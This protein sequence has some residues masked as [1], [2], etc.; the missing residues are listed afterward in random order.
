MARTPSKEARAKMLRA[1]AQILFR[2]GI[3]A[4]TVEAVARRSGVAKTT[5][6]RHFGGL[7]GLVNAT[8]ADNVRQRAGPDTG[9][10]KGDLREIQQNYLDL[11]NSKTNREVFA[12]MMTR[13]IE[14]PAA[15]AHFRK[16]RSEPRGPTVVALQ[17][18]IAR[19]EVSPTIDI[20]LASHVI[21]GPLMS[22]RFV[23][24]SELTEDE[25]EAL[26]DMIL[27]ALQSN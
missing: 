22:K 7:D 11:A 14:D 5:L 18:A 9:S 25:F 3:G 8:V 6:Y 4:V 20:E 27:G 2:D 13:A 16:E 15:A 1:T 26:L 21:Q 24:N 10:L 12:W 17:R 19:G 23:D